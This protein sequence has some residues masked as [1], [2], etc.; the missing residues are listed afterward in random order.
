MKEIVTNVLS[1]G[2]MPHGQCLLWKP[3]LLWLH[4]ISDGV[5]TLAYYSIP[6]AL[7]ILVYKRRDV[8]FPWMLGLFAA[9][10]LL[11]GTTHLIAAWTLWQPVYWLEGGVKVVTATISILTA[12]LLV[13]VIPQAL[14]LPSPAQLEAAN[15]QLL[16]EV[17]ERKV[18]EEQLS[19]KAHELA[20]TNDELSRF[21]HLAVG[22]E[23]RMIE[24]KQEI[25]RLHEEL[26]R[27][28]VYAIP[29]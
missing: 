26:G 3:E 7:A 5:I 16:R 29:S 12:I 4:A 17:H 2:F 14:S 22:R 10:I 19:L 11:C 9:F 25:N 15:H 20:R 24:L 6:V 8:A 21:N 23:A 27:P 1:S 18:V 13:P 28:P